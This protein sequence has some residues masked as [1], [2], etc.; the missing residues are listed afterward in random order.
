MSEL[1]SLED[2]AL[3]SPES[4][5][6]QKAEIAKLGGTIWDTALQN[7]YM[8]ANRNNKLDDRVI[9]L[10]FWWCRLHNYPYVLVSRW[11]YNKRIEVS[12]DLI[13]Q[14]YRLTEAHKEALDS[15]VQSVGGKRAKGE[16]RTLLAGTTYSQAECDL[17]C[18][19]TVAEAMLDAALDA[20]CQQTGIAISEKWRAV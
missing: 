14:R 5:A 7:G 19:A 18:A 13:G 16:I 20:R 6:H 15:K 1:K 3:Y 17:E 10:W 9:G 12:M 4:V 8:T 2:V 11:S